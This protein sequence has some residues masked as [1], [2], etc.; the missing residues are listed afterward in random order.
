MVQVELLWFYIK[1]NLNY[2]EIYVRLG[3]SL[4][5]IT[6]VIQ[7]VN[8]KSYRE[9]KVRMTKL[10][11]LTFQLSSHGESGN[12]ENGSQEKAYYEK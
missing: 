5:L 3:V 10:T 7:L 9:T 1:Y 2:L 4:F 6:T 11:A 8:I 12:G